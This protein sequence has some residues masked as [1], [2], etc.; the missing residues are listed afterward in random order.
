MLLACC[1]PFVSISVLGQLEQEV[2]EVVHLDFFKKKE[3][4]GSFGNW[5]Y[6]VMDD[7]GGER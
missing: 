3:R 7:G 1:Q 5:W 2:C 6:Q 4:D